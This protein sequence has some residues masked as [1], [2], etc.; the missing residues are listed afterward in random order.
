MAEQD[1]AE[2][3]CK[4]RRCF[5]MRMFITKSLKILISV[6]GFVTS[7]MSVSADQFGD[8]VRNSPAIAVVW[9][10]EL[11]PDP[12]V[13]DNSMEFLIRAKVVQVAK[14]DL[15]QDEE[16]EVVIKLPINDHGLL[17]SNRNGPFGLKKGGGCIMFLKPNFAADGK[18]FI[19]YRFSEIP[20]GCLPYDLYTLERIKREMN[21][22]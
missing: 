11:K 16:I 10:R 13:S 8:L 22:G 4:L 3:G 7:S 18:T 14:G 12:S 2:G 5:V 20:L 19:H 21:K 9:I 1:Q 15:E 17:L 6:F